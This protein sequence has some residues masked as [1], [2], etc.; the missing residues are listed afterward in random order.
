M[1]QRTMGYKRLDRIR[2][3]IQRGISGDI[4][5]FGV[6]EGYSLSEIVLCLRGHG[7]KNKV[8]GFDSFKGIP[9][10]GGVWHVGEFYSSLENTKGQLLHKL[11]N[12]DDITLV[13][14][15]FK[16]VLTDE[17]KNKL[18]ITNASL[19]HIDSDLYQSC[20][21]VLNWCKS[22]IGRGTY[23]FFDEWSGGEETAWREFASENKIQFAECGVV[24]DQ[25]L[26]EVR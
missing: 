18:N 7:M 5:E 3:V 13:E 14:G 17:L 22:F 23:I 24:E 25:F 4:L 11:G 16:E 20:K 21:T 1:D 15:T 26:I 8:F 9:E 6:Y 2:S 12:I 19:I 10:N